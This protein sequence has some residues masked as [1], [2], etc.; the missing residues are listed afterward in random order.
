MKK[1]LVASLLC[2]AMAA[3]MMMGCSSSSKSNEKAKTE[4]AAKTD[5]SKDDSDGYNKSAMP[6][7]DIKVEEASAEKVQEFMNDSDEKTVLVDARAQESYS[8]WALEGAKNGGHLKNSVL[9]S[10]RWLDCYYGGGDYGST[11]PRTKYLEREVKDQGITK[12]SEVIVY[13]YSGEQA[14]MLLDIFKSKV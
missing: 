6:T 13:D 9:F 2:V 4:D 11:T 10:S 14:K 7:G 3:S 1:K 5:E 12:D 8:G